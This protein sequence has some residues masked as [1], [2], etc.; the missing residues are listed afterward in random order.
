MMNVGRAFDVSNSISIAEKEVNRTW[1]TVERLKQLFKFLGPAFI[2]SVAYIDPGNF[3]TNISGGSIFNYNLVWVILWSN[4]MA[5]FLQIMSAKL[6]IA[7]GKNLTQISKEVFSKRI[8]WFFYFVAA[9]AAMATTLAEFLG[10]V[11]GFNL[12]FGIPLPYAAILTA[13]ITFAI[14]TLQKYGQRVVEVVITVLVAVICGA[15]TIELFLAKPDWQQVALHT[16]MPSLPNGQAV[17]IAAG[18]LGATVM[19]HVIYLHSQLVQHRNDGMSLEEKRKHLKMEKID[20][21]V[22]MNIAFVVNA[23]MVI[24][25]ASVFFS[26]GM[27]VDS[28][29]TAHRSLE[30]LLGGLSSGAFGIALLASG[31]SSSAVGAMAGE[32]VMDGFVDFKMPVNL[33][34]IITMLPGI[35]VIAAGINPMKALVLSQVSLSFA[36]PAA[37][38]PMLIITGRKKIM[39]EFANTAW[40]KAV[41][42]LITFIIIALNAAL[43]Y[44]TF[45]GNV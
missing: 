15:Y 24:V 14:I 29:E 31:F 17:L 9:I 28:I 34:R 7:A 30:P 39:G 13:I 2:V 12:L 44:L 38:I 5:I 22:A 43:L 42:W 33:R 35:L 18:M 41:G 4:L 20:V 19:P 25:S 40:V 26:R 27:V 11:L 32:T 6:G 3:A 37:I 10:G 23:A 21:A 45:T 16:F 36:L 1:I 8:N